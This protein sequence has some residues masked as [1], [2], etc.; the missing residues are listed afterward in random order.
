M[1]PNHEIV[2]LKITLQDSHPPI[3]RR[4]L[5]EKSLNFAQLHLTVQLAMGWGNYHLFEFSVNDQRISLPF[6]DPKHPDHKGLL[7]WLGGK[8][9]PSH[10]DLAE[11][12]ARLA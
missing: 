3:W 5:V 4:V 11:I 2:Q 7:E 8:Y 1:N 10:F 12:N 9:D 6:D